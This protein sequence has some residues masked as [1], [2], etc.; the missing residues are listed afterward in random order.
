MRRRGVQAEVLA[1]LSLVMVA[2]TA[3]LAAFFFK[4]HSVQVERIQGLLGRALAAEARAPTFSVEAVS[5][6][7]HWWTLRSGDR[8]REKTRRAG[9]IDSAS[10]TLAEEA[11]ESGRPLLSAGAPWEPIRFAMVVAPSGEVAVARLP[12]A[13]A[14]SSVL[15]LLLADAA[16][17]TAFGAYLLRRRVMLPLRR[18][19]G[20]ARA[21]GEGGPGAR[22]RV[23]GVGEV[24]DL[25]WAFNEMSEALEKRTGALE[26][27]VG[28]LREANQ[29]LRRARA[30]LDRAER[31]A[32]VGR[33]AAGV[34]HE[35]GNPMG[36]L[37][38]FLDLALR[39]SGLSEKGR[40]HLSRAVGEGERVRT[41]LRQLL[42]F[43]RPPRATAEPVDLGALAEQSV[44]LVRA[45]KRYAPVDLRV[46]CE[47]GIPS[48]MA[49]GS[50]VL[51]VL[52][53]LLL[54]A[55]DAASAASEPRIRVR[56]R[57]SPLQHREG[58]DREAARGR[59]GVDAVECEVADNGSGVAEED[60]ERI[61]DPFYTTK[62]PGEGT[63]LGL[64]NAQRL[65]EELGGVLEYA[66]SDSLGGAAFLLR[67]PV[68]PEPAGGVGSRVRGE[69]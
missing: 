61:F 48:V 12:A 38:A 16:I 32:A 59:A 23:E 51:Q 24:A 20:A 10:L 67:L 17:F 46:E 42:D 6:D 40:D 56:V 3:L 35:V 52:L 8:P 11:M 45:Q 60:R 55:A 21:M 43:S 29:S 68:Q 37:L 1:S 18:V 47:A 54:N 34:A 58:E 36:A 2:A 33:L 64:A 27:A 30:G 9:A 41:I 69:R 57:R 13:V 4:T 62:P 63:G 65:A 19:A 49:D 22:V 14:R 28:E 25:A 5:P 7:I 53:N 15:G 44:G 26:K 66:T 39:D 50:M 31:L